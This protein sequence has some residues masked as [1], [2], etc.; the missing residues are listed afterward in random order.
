M[1]TR[2]T[3]LHP[4]VAPGA[5]L[6]APGI[7]HDLN[8]LP[9]SHRA[10]LAPVPLHLKPAPVAVSG[11]SSSPAFTLMEVLVAMSLMSLI[12][13]VLMAVFSNTQTAFRAGITQTDVLSG[14]RTAMELLTQDARLLTASG[15]SGPGTLAPWPVNIFCSNNVNASTY[16]SLPAS[17]AY[18]TNVIQSVFF[19]GRQN[20]TW[21]GAGYVVLPNQA[22]NSLFPLYRYNATAS[23]QTGPYALFTN[24]TAVFAHPSVVTNNYYWSHLMDGVVHLV[25]RAYDTNGMWITNGYNYSVTPVVAPTNLFN[26]VSYPTFNGESGYVMYSNNLP[27]GVDIQLG[28]LE[29]AALRRLQSLVNL[30]P[31]VYVSYLQT[32]SANQ[33]ELFRQHV[34]V[35]NC[36]FTSYQ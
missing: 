28:V 3:I 25:V 15:G 4:D 20:T 19:L 26:T 21:T 16:M 35:P 17:A 23:L 6:T 36:D 31:N 7:G 22:N 18:R 10:P 14:G 12:V 34:R 24:F 33:M 27:A 30:S 1:I 32:N 5:R 29:D 2:F 13:L 8:C 11:P 9:A